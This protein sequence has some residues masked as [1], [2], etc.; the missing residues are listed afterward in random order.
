MHEHRTGK[1]PDFTNA[2]LVMGAVNLTWMFAVLWALLGLG[3]VLAV[4]LAL[5]HGITRLA[6]ARRR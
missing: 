2:A 5:N 3:W 4:A 1:A 6:R